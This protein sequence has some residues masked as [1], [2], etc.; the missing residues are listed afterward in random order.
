MSLVTG[1]AVGLLTI[2]VG[3]TGMV[4]FVLFLMKRTKKTTADAVKSAT[5]SSR[6]APSLSSFR[7]S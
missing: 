4:A 6:V 1:L 5:L 7:F 3:A 2:V